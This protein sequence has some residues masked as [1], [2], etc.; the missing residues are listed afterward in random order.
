MLI[1]RVAGIDI[2]LI[3]LYF[4]KH[5]TPSWNGRNKK[6]YYCSSIF[7]FLRKTVAKVDGWFYKGG[8][9][10]FQSL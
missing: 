9:D 5:I 7:F 10:T 3:M 2:G 6:C 1:I 4:V 8:E